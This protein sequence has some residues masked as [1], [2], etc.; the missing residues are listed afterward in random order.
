[1]V[2]SMG[3][4]VRSCFKCKHRVEPSGDGRFRLRCYR[5]SITIG[6]LSPGYWH[7]VAESIAKDC[8][9]YSEEETWHI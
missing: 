6:R 3:G 4:N 8:E 7:K 9:K 2:S 1:V 5:K